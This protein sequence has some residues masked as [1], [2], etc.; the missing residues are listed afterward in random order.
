MI[1]TA[2]SKAYSAAATW[3]RR[4][5]ADPSR[6]KR[7]DRPVISVGNLN[8]GGS[9][10]T[11]VVAHLAALLSARGER[12]AI[13]SRGYA[14]T[15]PSDGVAIVSDGYNVLAPLE[16]AGDEP[17]ML[18]RALP[19]VPVLVCADRF[20]AGRVAEGRLGATVHLL[21][22]GFQH[23]K[24]ARDVDLLIA[25]PADLTDRVLPAGRLREPLTSARVAHA[26]LLDERASADVDALTRALGVDTVYRMRRAVGPPCWMTTGEVADVKE[27]DVVVGVA[28]IA[29]PDR[30]FADL[31]AARVTLAERLVFR[32]H[33]PYSD[34]DVDRIAEAARAVNAKA[35]LTTEKDAVRLAIRRP[36]SLPIAVV[37][38]RVT[39]EPPTFADWLIGRLAAARRL[40]PPAPSPQPPGDA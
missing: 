39:I 18:A 17:L 26:L 34:A 38:L 8:T 25:G 37:P 30:F 2:A 5:Y 24:L 35:I 1:L 6:R 9:G 3:R 10:K 22:D 16:R 27:N 40:E 21:D 20:E 4:W 15:A 31:E 13:L 11:P 28:G 12:P 14:R 23:V 33:H 36:F 32:D 7:L 19:T 29:R